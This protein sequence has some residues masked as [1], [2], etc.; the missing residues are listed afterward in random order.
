MIFTY[1]YYCYVKC[2]KSLDCILLVVI[3]ELGE[4]GL[5]LIP[6]LRHFLSISDQLY[7]LPES[8]ELFFYQ[9]FET[10]GNSIQNTVVQTLCLED[11]LL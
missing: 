3:E 2:I 1:Y 4:L 6:P 5:L 11:P 9:G 8:G 7:S 10:I